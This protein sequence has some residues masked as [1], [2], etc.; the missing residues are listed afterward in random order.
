M[1]IDRLLKRRNVVRVNKSNKHTTR[2][3][4]QETTYM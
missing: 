3:Y 2:N 1:Y 4:I